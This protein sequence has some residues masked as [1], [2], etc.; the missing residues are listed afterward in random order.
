[1]P[2]PLLLYAP[3]RQTRRGQKVNK[4]RGVNHTLRERRQKLLVFYNAVLKSGLVKITKSPIVVQFYNIHNIHFHI[5]L[6]DMSY[7]S[8][9][10][11]ILFLMNVRLLRYSTEIIL[12]Y[13]TYLLG[14]IVVHDN[15][16]FSG[17]DDRDNDDTL[18]LCALVHIT[19]NYCAVC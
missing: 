3:L 2:S 1:M 4:S 19:S 9:I 13:I 16:G 15:D 14:T 18:L 5:I 12:H 6:T 7:Y 10:L 8:S 17:C 11:I